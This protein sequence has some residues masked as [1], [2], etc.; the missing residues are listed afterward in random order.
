MD[1][2]ETTMDELLLTRLLSQPS[3]CLSPSLGRRPWRNITFQ[4]YQAFQ[5]FLADNP[6]FSQAAGP[7]T[8]TSTSAPSS[9]NGAPAVPPVVA[10]TST[11]ESN[12]VPAAVTQSYISN[13]PQAPPLIA[14][15][16]YQAFLGS[17]T[18]APSAATLN[19][20]HV[21]RERVRH[22][23]AVLPRSATSSL[24]VRRPRGPAQA[25]PSLNRARP[26]VPSI[27]DC[28]VEG[29][30]TPS[31][32]VMVLVYPPLEPDSSYQNYRLY[33]MLHPD[34]V[35]QLRERHLVYSYVLPLDSLVNNL[36]G[37]VVADMAASPAAYVFPV[38]RRAST[39]ASAAAITT[40]Q[41]LGVVDRGRVH[42]R[43][44]TVHFASRGSFRDRHFLVRLAVMGDTLVGLDPDG[45]HHTCGSRHLYVLFPCDD[46][47]M[48]QDVSDT[49]GGESNNDDEN[50]V[51][52]LWP[53]SRASTSRI[54]Q[55]RS[56][57]QTLPEPAASG[58]PRLSLRDL[59]PNSPSTPTR[60]VTSDHPLALPASMWDENAVHISRSNGIFT[61]QRF[62]DAIFRAATRGT[63]ISQLRV[64]GTDVDEAADRFAQMLDDAGELGDYTS[65]L[66]PDRGFGLTNDMAHGEGVEREVLITLFK[67]YTN[68]ESTWFQRGEKEVLTLRALYPAT[69]L[70]PAPRRR[71]VEFKRLG[72]LC[73]LLLIFGQSLSPMSPAIF[74]YLIHCRNFHALHPSFMGEWFPL[75]RSLIMAWIAT[76]PESH[77]LAAFNAALITFVGV[78]AA[79]FRVRDHATH[80]ALPVTI[81]FNA[82]L[83]NAPFDRPELENFTDGFFLRC[84]NGFNFPQAVRNF[85]GGSETFL[86]VVE[87]SYICDA[88][89]I[90]PHIEVVNPPDLALLVGDLQNHTGDVTLTFDMLI[91][92]FLRGV[93]IP[94]PIQFE[95]HKGAFHRIIDLSRIS[96]PGFRAQALAW[97]ATGSPFMDPAGGG[98]VLGPI[99]T[100]GEGYGP[101]GSSAAD[102][103]RLA[104]VGTFQIQTCNRTAR[105]PVQY[106]LDLA[107]L[108]YLPQSE[109]SDF[110]EAFDFWFLYQCLVSIGRHNIV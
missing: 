71:L 88:D 60:P 55:V 28:L 87:T 72:A 54:P 69:S 45:R 91:E 56:A 78:E 68:A 1:H 59:A 96:T 24:V 31:I 12:P 98:I 73:A 25:T 43:L 66:A 79:A 83:A 105:Y 64:R 61:Q 37:R 97:A 90:L 92:R 93:G 5:Q 38:A 48:G 53:A 11:A 39:A 8:S 18:L 62:T 14:P 107:Q 15:A 10:Q 102:R 49:S 63:Q 29:A 34:F 110:Q 65:V 57:A 84:R 89:S 4:Q 6:D 17:S 52:Q 101:H 35:E 20:T 99:N 7:P 75:L 2:S 86:S 77:D 27:S 3:L 104:S 109:P 82:V 74:Q 103:D 30:D 40:L 50:V 13:R 22:A 108:Q 26:K 58:Q 36:L 81:V 106:V 47:T 9:T 85:Q 94:C 67:R 19:T 44:D 21:N 76:P 32:N 51:R 23:N 41:L 70:I 80:L 46:S 16:S 100:H 42:P 95:A 33:R